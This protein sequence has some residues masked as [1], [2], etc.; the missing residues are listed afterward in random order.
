[1]KGGSVLGRAAVPLIVGLAAIIVYRALPSADYHPDGYVNIAAMAE[2]FRDTPLPVYMRSLLVVHALYDFLV[3]VTWKMI[4][5][6]GYQGRAIYAFTAATSWLAGMGIAVFATTLHRITGSR[7]IS[8]AAALGLA[9]SGGWWMFAN[10]LEDILPTVVI[11]LIAFHLAVAAVQSGRLW[12]WAAAG[13]V[14]GLAVLAHNTNLMLAPAIF[15]LALHR[16]QGAIARIALAASAM[17]AAV[18]LPLL[19]V[20]LAF[21]Q[22]RHFGSFAGWVFFTRNFGVWGA[23]GIDWPGFAMTAARSIIYRKSWIIY[24][25]AAAFLALVVWAAARASTA[26][27]P[28]RARPSARLIVL[29][30]IAWILPVL[31]FAIYWNAIDIEFF[32]PALPALWIVLAIGA[33]KSANRIPYAASCAAMALII[34]LANLIGTAIPDSNPANIPSRANTN[35]LGQMLDGRELVLT[36]M[37]CWTSQDAAY[38]LQID[39][40]DMGWFLLHTKHIENSDFY[41]LLNHRIGRALDRGRTVYLHRPIDPDDPAWKRFVFYGGDLDRMR[42]LFQDFDVSHAFDIGRERF[43]L[44]QM[45]MQPQQFHEK[46]LN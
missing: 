4:T 8:A 46:P 33:Q 37:T 14:A 30:C 16:R 2:R 6:V 25:A 42:A 1:M 18:L 32:M 35:A 31:A 15:V 13:V 29:S 41:G 9:F 5:A 19:L 27:D 10:N 43:L 22:I 3:V 20:G 36:P 26:R 45:P 40:L 12:L 11:F 17:A 28:Q 34:F 21:G 39:V 23:G 7:F 44:I 38:F 24:P